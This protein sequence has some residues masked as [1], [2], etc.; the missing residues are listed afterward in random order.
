ISGKGRKRRRNGKRY[1]Q[2]SRQKLSHAL[3]PHT[4]A[5]HTLAPHTLA[6]DAQPSMQAF[7]QTGVCAVM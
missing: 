3:S 6:P 7:G 4:L 2:H 5:P 1:G